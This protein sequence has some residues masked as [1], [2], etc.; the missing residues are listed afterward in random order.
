MQIGVSQNW[1]SYFGAGDDG[2]GVHDSVGVFLSDFG[3]EEGSHS[4]A[5]TTAQGVGQLKSLKAIARFG[6][7]ANHV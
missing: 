5:R 7:F 6:L 2:E 3:D 4:T 1:W